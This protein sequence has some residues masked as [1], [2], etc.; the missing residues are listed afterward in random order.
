MNVRLWGQ[1]NLLGGGI[2]FSSFSDAIRRIGLFG[3]LVEE[4]DAYDS[5]LENNVA[6]GS[7]NDVNIMFGPLPKP[8]LLKGRVVK[9]AVFE[10]DK[11][12][13]RYL[14]YLSRSDA[15][16]VPSEWAKTVL[17][18]HGFK[19]GQIDVVPE[20]VDSAVFHPFLRGHVARDNIFRFFM[21]GKYEL[22]KGFPEILEGFNKAF[23]N[24]TTIKLLLKPDHLYQHNSHAPTQVEQLR[25]ELQRL[26]LS[27]VALISG[28]YSTSD[29]AM[30]NN[31]CDAQLFPSRAEGWGLP[32]IEGIAS[33]LPTIC[34]YFSGPTQ[35]LGPIKQHLRLLD[36]KESEVLDPRS[37]GNGAQGACWAIS[38]P[39]DIAEALTEIHENYAEWSEQAQAASQIIRDEF[40]W[41]KSAVTAMK[42][43]CA[44]SIFKPE[45]SVNL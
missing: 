41:E 27:N 17:L 32:L 11:L 43:L 31:L 13:D 30:M 37:I 38:S 22:R 6:A 33:G 29:M 1:R 12:D 9:W 28:Q 45:W 3:A 42:A 40:S 39:D 44:R 15:I 7:H 25:L 23:G 19:A 5:N 2:F 8:L 34:N 20:G 24:S 18:N 4:F 26:K 36:Y 14:S 16:W 10:A 21:C 35:Y